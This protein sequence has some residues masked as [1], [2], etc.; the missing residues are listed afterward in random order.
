MVQRGGAPGLRLAE[1]PMTAERAPASK[2]KA[3]AD[4]AVR[5]R[6][7]PRTARLDEE[8]VAVLHACAAVGVEPLVLKGVVLARTLYRSDETRGYFD[9]DLLVAPD[10]LP[11]VGRVLADRGYRNLTELIG[12]DDMSG[13]LHADTWSRY[14]PELGNT[15]IDVHWRL[16]GCEASPAVVWRVLSA[17]S[18][19]I[20]LGGHQVRALDRPGLALHLALHVFQHGPDDLKAIADLERGLERWSPEVWHGA[21]RLAAELGATEALA[22]GLWL[23]P[24]GDAFA[25]RLQLPVP[26]AALRDVAQREARPRGVYHLRAFAEASTL[27]ERMRVVR[28][29]LLP[30]RA[31]MIRQ[32]PWAA[33]N[34]YRL[35]AAYCA[36]L[37][38]T[39][40]WAARAWR[41]RRSTSGPRRS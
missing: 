2:G 19:L 38:R 1:P 39:P 27:A 23:V 40:V 15:A 30:K 16:D 22:A 32:R 17:R 31:W 10:D 34:R 4:F 35:V 33:T 12:V 36:H 5:A 8:T 26:E 3:L 29:S 21:A 41:F 7:A 14:V 9:V 6:M 20:D 37:V 18:K 28:Q 11:A 24:D 13:Y 25:R